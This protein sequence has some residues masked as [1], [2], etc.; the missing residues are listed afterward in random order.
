MKAIDRA[1]RDF[2]RTLF[3]PPLAA[4]V[5]A[6]E[7]Q[8]NVTFPQDF[9]DYLLNYN[10]GFFAEP[11]IVP[12]EDGTPREHLLEMRGIRASHPDAELGGELY[13]WDDNDP[14]QIVPIGVTVSNYFII[15]VT[16]GGAEDY[17]NILLRTFGEWFFLAED[18]WEFFALLRAPQEGV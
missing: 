15:L 16:A 10:G 17:G 18:I 8:I 5:S 13:L 14:P 11:E 12:P 2:C 3:P 9:R 6:L 1:Y 7:R 4:D